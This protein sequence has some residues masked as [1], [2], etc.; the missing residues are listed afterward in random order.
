MIG[1]VASHR[2]TSLMTS[3]FISGDGQSG[4][5]F[6]AEFDGESHH[7]YRFGAGAVSIGAG[8]DSIIFVM[9]KPH[10]LA[11]SSIPSRMAFVSP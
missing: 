7:E 4:I 10:S 9:H 11:A 2:F 8:I 3:A 1:A 6:D 5:E